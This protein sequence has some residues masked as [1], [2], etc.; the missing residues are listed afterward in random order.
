[1][2][3]YAVEYLWERGE[4]GEAARVALAAV[5]AEPKFLKLY[6]L[7]LRTDPAEGA[8]RLLRAVDSDLID[9]SEVIDRYCVRGYR[10]KPT[11]SLRRALA[12]R[13]EGSPGQSRL[14][15]LL[16][17]QALDPSLALADYLRAPCELDSDPRLLAAIAQAAREAGRSELG[18]GLSLAANRLDSETPL[19]RA[20]TPDELTELE[21]YLEERWTPQA[22]RSLF[23]S[24]LALG[25]A[26]RARALV[27]RSAQHLLPDEIAEIALRLGEASPREGAWA[28]AEA[29]LREAPFAGLESTLIVVDP[30]RF[31][32]LHAELS[33]E[34]P[35]LERAW[36]NSR[37][38]A[39]NLATRTAPQQAAALVQ[40]YGEGFGPDALEDLVWALLGKEEELAARQVHRVVR[41][42]D[43][44]VPEWAEFEDE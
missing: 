38:R 44:R 30:Q 2:V 8:A 11:P 37:V 13:V 25:Q 19:A 39:L 32:A 40:S 24:Y 21:A 17:L 22:T 7:L 29:A 27:E 20:E 31:L 10:P 33:R 18:W 1:M 12:Q 23:D 42:I 9:L 36:A 6:D 4:R 16:L 43:P 28:F 15:R 14:Q 41:T 5:A 35:R 34:D 3:E 26:G